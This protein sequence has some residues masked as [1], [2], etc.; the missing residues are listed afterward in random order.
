MTHIQTT[1][2]AETSM[3]KLYKVATDSR[4]LVARKEHLDSIEKILELNRQIDILKAQASDEVAKIMGYMQTHELLV[5]ERGRQ[6]VIWKNASEKQTVD[7]AGLLTELNVPP[8][9]VAR[10][11]KSSP[12]ARTFNVQD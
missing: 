9:T 11:T 7:Y 3:R 2:D 12:G 8:A 10:F 1:S 6:L 5:D 4:P